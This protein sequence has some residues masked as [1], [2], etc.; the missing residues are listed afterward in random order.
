MD[1]RDP[2]KVGVPTPGGESVSDVDRPLSEVLPTRPGGGSSPAVGVAAGLAKIGMAARRRGWVAAERRGVPPLQAQILSI[3]QRSGG[4]RQRD[5]VDELGVAQPTASIAVDALIRRGLV[6][7]ERATGDRRALT[8]ALTDEGWNRAERAGQSDLLLTAVDSLSAE[9]Q[10]VFLLGLLK[11]IHALEERGALPAS[12][13]CLSCSHFRSDL[14]EGSPLPHHCAAFEI[15]LSNR[16]LRVECAAHEAAPVD[17]VATAW[18][19]VASVA[20]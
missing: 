15:A 16:H 3:L 14:H 20:D 10:E 8:I 6:R 5:L 18:G 13:M 4:V 9:E 2:D 19:T 12:R 17:D 7:K 1:V 11:M